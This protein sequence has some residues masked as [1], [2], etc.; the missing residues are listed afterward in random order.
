[1]ASDFRMLVTLTNSG[2]AVHR[3]EMASSRF[4]DQ[5]DWSGYLGEVDLK[6][7]PGGVQVQVVGA[8]TPAAKATAD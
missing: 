5:H 1:M 2:A 4:R 3:A 7:A 6:D 8:G